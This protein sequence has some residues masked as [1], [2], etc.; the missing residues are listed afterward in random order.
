MMGCVC[1]IILNLIIQRWGVESIYWTH[2]IC[3]R[4]RLCDAR[5][6][7]WVFNQSESFDK[8]RDY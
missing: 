8:Q 6:R 3:V 5:I 2:E 7:L 1:R 4:G